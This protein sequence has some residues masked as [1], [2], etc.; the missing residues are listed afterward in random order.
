LGFWIGKRYQSR[1]VE[2]AVRC[3]EDDIKT[4]MCR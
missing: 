4:E 3:L 1:H 2:R